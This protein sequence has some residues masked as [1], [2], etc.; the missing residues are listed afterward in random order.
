MIIEFWTE[1]GSPNFTLLKVGCF[2]RSDFTIF[3]LVLI[4]FEIIFK[5]PTKE[6]QI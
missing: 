3:S 4:G 5:F 2:W 6:S 1:W